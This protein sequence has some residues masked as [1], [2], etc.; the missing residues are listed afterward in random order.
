MVGGY[1]AFDDPY[2]YPGTLV[3]KN[4]LASRMR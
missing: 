3:L 4:L 1:E 2:L